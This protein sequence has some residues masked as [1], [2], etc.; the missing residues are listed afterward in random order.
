MRLNCSWVTHFGRTATSMYSSY[1]VTSS[2]C[3]KSWMVGTS[4]QPI[5][6]ARFGRGMREN[7]CPLG[8]RTSGAGNTRTV[9]GESK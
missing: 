4:R 3:T 2:R 8:F 5:L 1:D 6:R 7:N 9:P